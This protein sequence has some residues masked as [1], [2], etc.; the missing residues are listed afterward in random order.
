VLQGRRGC[1]KGAALPRPLKA[2]TLRLLPGL[3]QQ[4][5][6]MLIQA[7]GVIEP[8]DKVAFG[9]AGGGTPVSRCTTS[10]AYSSTPRRWCAGEPRDRSSL[11]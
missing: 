2:S 5:A 11:I 1:A 8:E 3:A 7:Q 6:A 4:V 9:L 10:S